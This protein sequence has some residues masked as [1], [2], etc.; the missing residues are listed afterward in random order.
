MPH[1][2]RVD[3]LAT[4]FAPSVLRQRDA[5]G[6]CQNDRPSL[7]LCAGS[8]AATA[9]SW[10]FPDPLP[11]PAWPGAG[12]DSASGLLSGFQTLLAASRRKRK[13]SGLQA[14]WRP[15]RSALPRSAHASPIPFRKSL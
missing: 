14:R 11:P 4:Y 9:A 1:E 7:G 8:A 13:V 5:L 12:D 10:R 6:A 3:A 2:R 15:S